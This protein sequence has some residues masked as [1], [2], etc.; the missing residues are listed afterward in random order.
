MERR[1]RCRHRDIQLAAVEEFHAIMMRPALRHSHEWPRLRELFWSLA[2][3][4]PQPQTPTSGT[5]P[6]SVFR[7]VQRI[8]LSR[9]AQY[10]ANSTAEQQSCMDVQ[11][12]LDRLLRSVE[13]LSHSL[14]SDQPT[15]DLVTLAI[16]KLARHSTKGGSSCWKLNG[17]EQHP[18]ITWLLQSPLG[19]A[20]RTLWPELTVKEDPQVVAFLLLA[21]QQMIP[22]NGGSITASRRCVESHP[23]L[24]L[25][26]REGGGTREISRMAWRIYTRLMPI[27]EME[28]LPDRLAILRQSYYSCDDSVSMLDLLYTAV[29]GVLASA[30]ARDCTLMELLLLPSS[31]SSSSTSSTSPVDSLLAQASFVDNKSGGSF[32]AVELSA[33]VVAC[34]I[35]LNE[36]LPL[37]V[38]HQEKWIAYALNLLEA[39]VEKYHS[40]IPRH[41]LALTVLPLLCAINSSQ[42]TVSLQACRLLESVRSN[43]CNRR[44][45]LLHNNNNDCQEDYSHARVESFILRRKPFPHLAYR[46]IQMLPP[47]DPTADTHPQRQ[48]DDCKSL[49][50]LCRQTADCLLAVV[51]VD[52]AVNST[53]IVVSSIDRLLDCPAAAIYPLE[54]FEFLNFMLDLPDPW[55]DADDYTLAEVK[56]YILTDAIPRLIGRSGRDVY[57]VGRILGILLPL[58]LDYRSDNIISG[59]DST[60]SS[61][62][63]VALRSLTNCWRNYNRLWSHLF[64]ALQRII[65]LREIPEEMELMTLKIIRYLLFILYYYY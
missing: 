62:R 53:D 41:I 15:A 49:Y 38:S 20:C 3:D 4:Q 47:H 21:Q 26:H 5:S 63:P 34:V 31:S 30:V 2:L 24:Q 33:I 14:A 37:A 11:E 48:H 22:P 36:L 43:I 27:G 12:C 65:D 45:H 13:H 60:L 44:R 28:L 39:L 50:S 56:L 35:I 10:Y 25:L 46:L 55:G 29:E 8:L 58:L 16:H 54:C 19:W 52:G 40:A 61:L 57:L 32:D 42:S 23:R 7:L 9:L 59:N 6:P 1:L 17:M 64:A 18:L 51:A